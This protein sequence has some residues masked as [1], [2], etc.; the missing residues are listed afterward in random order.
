MRPASIAVVALA[1]GGCSGAVDDGPDLPVTRVIPPENAS[2]AG[3]QTR[4]L[5]PDLVNFLVEMRGARA[6]A[7]VD[8]YA[9]CA[10]AQY[11]LI[12]GFGFARHIRTNVEEEGGVWRGDAVYTVSPALPPGARNIDAEVVVATCQQDGIPTV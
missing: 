2:Y 10:A 8:A 3:V 9:R 6:P 5:E 4:L 12:R 11:A 1:L 7:D